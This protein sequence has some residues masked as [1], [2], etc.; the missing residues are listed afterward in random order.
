MKYEGKAKVNDVD[1]DNINKS[2]TDYLGYIESLKKLS[3][4]KELQDDYKNLIELYEKDNIHRENINRD[5]KNNNG[6]N[7]KSEELETIKDLTKFR[8]DFESKIVITSKQKGIDIE[9]INA[10]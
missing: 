5:L 3:P 7:I 8:N 1:K 9:E 10:K 2:S 6:K 4:P